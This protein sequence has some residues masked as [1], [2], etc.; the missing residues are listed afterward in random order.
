MRCVTGASAKFIE[1]AYKALRCRIHTISVL[2]GDIRTP[3]CDD[4]PREFYEALAPLR[5]RVGVFEVIRL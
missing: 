2:V 3:R 4:R 1:L 5:H